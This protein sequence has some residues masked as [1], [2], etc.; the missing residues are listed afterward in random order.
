MCQG[1]CRCLTRVF[2]GMR[3]TPKEETG[4]SVADR[5]FSSSWWYQ[6]SY[7]HP[8]AFSRCGRA[9]CTTHKALLCPGSLITPGWGRLGICEKG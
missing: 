3:A 2:L 6:A 5:P 8:A 1:W 4:V 9:L 7:C